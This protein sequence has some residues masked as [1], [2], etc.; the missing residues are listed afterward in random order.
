MEE[1]PLVSLNT[2]SVRQTFWGRT[3]EPPARSSLFMVERP[4]AIKFDN[5]AKVPWGMVIGGSSVS[6]TRRL[7]LLMKS[8]GDAASLNSFRQKNTAI[9]SVTGD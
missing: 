6:T 4:P 7:K 1:P 9:H 8:L 3:R 5:R 2:M